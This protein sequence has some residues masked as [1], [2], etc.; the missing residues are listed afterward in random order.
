MFDI[1]DVRALDKVFHA[2]LIRMVESG[3]AP[4]YAELSRA[5]GCTSE[6]ARQAVHTIFKRGY[7]GWVHPGTDL[8]ASF[9]PLNSQPTQYRISYGESNLG[10]STWLFPWRTSSG[11]TLELF[12]SWC[13]RLSNSAG[14]RYPSAECRRCEL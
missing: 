11:D 7:P 4:H 8:I 3:H 1:A 2:I 5:L 6:E 14:A 10:S 12:C 9:P 13:H